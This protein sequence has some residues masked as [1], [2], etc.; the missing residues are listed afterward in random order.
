VKLGELVARL[1][2]SAPRPDPRRVLGE[3]WLT[4]Q[5]LAARLAERAA[6]LGRYPWLQAALADAA[7][8]AR[9]GAERV[10]AA[11]A[12]RGVTPPA[13]TAPPP[14]SGSAWAQ[15][16]AAVE[17]LR[18][19]AET[20]GAAAADLERDH[21]DV[22]A[23][24]RE[25]RTARLAA[26]HRLT[27]WLGYLEPAALEGADAASPDALGAPEPPTAPVTGR[28]DIDGLPAAA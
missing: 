22:A 23:L 10:A 4:E 28:L 5:H 20:Y 16:R 27:W 2:V 3:T 1:L 19:A 6:R 18:V 26:W 12:A 9:R 11:L 13:P 14:R 24:L 8:E 15:L 25:L 17:D 21:G 7:A